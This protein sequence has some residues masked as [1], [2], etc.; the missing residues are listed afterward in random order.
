MIVV[1]GNEHV[2]AIS[3]SSSPSLR[4]DELGAYFSPWQ[5]S[6]QPLHHLWYLLSRALFAKGL[7]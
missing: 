3:S 2:L 5:G 4:R 6:L 7:N 1:S